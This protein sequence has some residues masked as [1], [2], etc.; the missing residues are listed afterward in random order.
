MRQCPV[1]SPDVEELRTLCAAAELGSLGRAAVRLGTSQPAL[2]KR[3]ANL[4]M[5]AGARLLERSPHGVKLTPAGR[6]LYEEARRMLAESDRVAEVVAGIAR[7]GG[8]VRLAASHSVTDA[9]VAEALAHLDDRGTRAVELVSANSS[10]VR[11][12]V[13][14]GRADLGV[15]ASRPNRTPYPAVRELSLA[16]DEVI[17]AV[18]PDHPWARRS[19][20]SLQEFVATPM[21]VRDPSSNARWT[22]DALLRERQLTPAPTL[23]EAATPDAARR[24][25]RARG[26]PV[27]LSRNVLTG[28][29]FCEV[30]VDGLSFRREYV[31]ILPAVG[32]PSGPVQALIAQLR[33]QATIWLRDRPLTWA[34]EPTV[35]AAHRDRHDICPGRP[36]GGRSSVRG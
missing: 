11:D 10:V 19:E 15:A 9:L 30:R 17:C 24:E 16:P 31:F 29:D 5:L 26:A 23:V 27:L 21:V 25:A 13:A 33:R 14:D 32:E 18:P 4:E 34:A 35:I 6:R 20:V 1:R 12:L 2:S 3:L 22:V 36:S 28:H 8:P 7:A